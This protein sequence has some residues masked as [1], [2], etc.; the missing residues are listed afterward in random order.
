M[1]T[2]DFQMFGL[3]L[4]KIRERGKRGKQ[5]IG[6]REEG[7]KRQSNV[8]N[9]NNEWFSSEQYGTQKLL[10]PLIFCRIYIFHNK[11]LEI[12][13]HASHLFIAMHN[14]FIV[15]H[16]ISNFV[17]VRSLMK[18]QG[19]IPLLKHVFFFTIRDIYIYS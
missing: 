14:I 7:W 10:Y 15:I 4:K 2:K 17:H 11:M 3:K 8:A 18:I 16:N 12:H 19:H 6:G 5:R 1:G 13:K 9:D